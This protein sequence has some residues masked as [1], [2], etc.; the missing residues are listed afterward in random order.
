LEYSNKKNFITQTKKE[1]KDAYDV[2][3]YEIMRKKYED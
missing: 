3:I 2:I 1:E